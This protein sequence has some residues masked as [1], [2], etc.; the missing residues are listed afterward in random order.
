MTNSTFKKLVILDVDVKGEC[1]DQLLPVVYMCDCRRPV[2]KD[3][4]LDVHGSCFGVRYGHIYYPLQAFTFITCER[5][6]TNY[7]NRIRTHLKGRDP[8]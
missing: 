7:R 8:G 1:N 6:N 5:R 3:P 4:G 2:A